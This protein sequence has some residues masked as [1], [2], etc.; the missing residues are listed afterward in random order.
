MSKKNSKLRIEVGKA[1]KLK[2]PE[3]AGNADKLHIDYILD[4]PTSD[5][6]YDKLIVCRFWGRKRMCWCHFVWKYSTLAM[7]NNWRE[8]F[9][10]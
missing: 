10:K 1:Y 7:Y 2:H 3:D 6:V 4:N 9:K 5:N 8:I